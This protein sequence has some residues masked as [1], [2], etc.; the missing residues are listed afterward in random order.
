VGVVLGVTLGAWVGVF[1]GIGAAVA[2]ACGALAV[3]V[4]ATMVARASSGP[5]TVGAGVT[6]LPQAARNKANQAARQYEIIRERVC[7]QVSWD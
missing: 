4:A 2:V 6:L 1:V 7:M 3:R 5:A